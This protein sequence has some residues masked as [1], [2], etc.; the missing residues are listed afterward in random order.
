VTTYTAA[1]VT[2]MMYAGYVEN[3]LSPTF[4]QIGLNSVGVT[5]GTL[6]AG[7]AFDSAK[8]LTTANNLMGSLY[9]DNMVVGINGWVDIGAH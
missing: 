8:D 1:S 6:S 5:I 7:V 4:V 2:D 3:N 9:V